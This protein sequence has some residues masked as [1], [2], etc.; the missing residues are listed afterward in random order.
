MTLPRL[1]DFGIGVRLGVTGVLL[2]LAMG[3]WAGLFYMSHHYD[4]RDERPGLTVDDIK[5][6]YHGLPPRSPML[7]ALDRGHPDT[8]KK[9]ERDVLVK[10]LKSGKINENYDNPDLGDASP[11]EI[12]AGS[13]VKCHSS[14]AGDDQ[15]AARAIPLDSL[16]DI[17]KSAESAEIYPVP[18][19]GIAASMHAHAPALACWV[20]ALSALALMTRWRRGVVGFTVGATGLALFA[21]LAAWW[22]SR[23]FE[24]FVHVLIGAGAVLQAGLAVLTLMILIDLWLPKPSNPEAAR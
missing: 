17:R 1:R 16:T 10:W 23:K 7:G 24:A 18:P 15:A 8:L 6:A 13:C 2:T 21:D 22:V 20:L 9:G 3:Q 12:I 14:R 19:I 5:S 11:K 4:K